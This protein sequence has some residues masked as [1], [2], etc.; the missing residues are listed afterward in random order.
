MKL[1]F[2]AI[3]TCLCFLVHPVISQNN[4]WSQQ[5][6]S[7]SSLMGG[8]VVGGVQDNSAL[9]YN[10]G[11]IAYIDSAHLNVSANAYGMDYMQLKNGAGRDI[12]LTSLKILVY[13]QFISGLVKFKFIPKLKFAYGLLTRTRNEVK[14][15]A[16]NRG[17]Y[18]IIPNH[19]D[20]QYYY[21]TFDYELSSISQ[22]GGFSFAYKFTP[23]F[24]V[25]LTTFATY[26]HMDGARSTFSTADV[27]NPDPDSTYLAKFYSNEHY[28]VDHFGL[29][30][31][32][33][34]QFN[35]EKFKLGLTFTTPNISLFGFTRIG[36]TLEYNNQDRFIS[37]TVA[38]GRH[39][40]WLI[41]D[42][43]TNLA[44]TLR[45]PFSIAIGMEYDFPK[46]NTKVTFTTEYF[47]QVPLYNVA[48]SNDPVYI[49]PMDQYNN[50]VYDKP[51]MQ[52][53][54]ANSPV[55]NFALGFEQRISKKTTFYFGA[56]TDWNN[57][58]EAVKSNDLISNRI[59]QNYNHYMHFSSG[60]TYKKGHSDI[61][62]GINY[63]VGATGLRRQAINLSDPMVVVNSDKEYFILQGGRD[64]T[65]SANVHSVSLIIGYTY[66]LKR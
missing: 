25:G 41:S 42:D 32:L 40:S 39:P 19:P 54:A 6:G 5:Y 22:W 12:D 47:Y 1:K 17:Y 51:F 38:I 24:A 8:A 63:G 59:N 58:I 11:G 55:L 56:R 33:G 36:Q 4:Y 30:W 27:T 60:I 16:D 9:Y 14:M 13:P 31:K 52:L 18:D 46:T 37:D 50:V 15:H 43:K 66:Y 2:L 7:R 26:S 35:W 48:R 20:S 62:F 21:A 3:L 29:V 34:F 64:Q 28:N 10:P 61:T 65:I 57:G 53:N 45:S 44:T 23:R 49:R